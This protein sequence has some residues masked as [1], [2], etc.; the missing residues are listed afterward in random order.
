MRK[1]LMVSKTNIFLVKSCILHQPSWRSISNARE[2]KKTRSESRSLNISNKKNRFKMINNK[3]ANAF[4]RILFS[5]FR[6]LNHILCLLLCASVSYFPV[7][8]F[9]H[10]ILITVSIFIKKNISYKRADNRFFQMKCHV[11]L[12]SSLFGH[13]NPRPKDLM[14]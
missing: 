12:W 8:L 4:S 6:I 11:R 3:N 14:N 10:F 1:K 2:S 13:R 7:I 9:F 5:V